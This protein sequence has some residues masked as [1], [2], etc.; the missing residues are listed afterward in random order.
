[1]E[2]KRL[3]ASLVVLEMIQLMFKKREMQDAQG[4]ST[5]CIQ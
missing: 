5:L 1:M 3:H 4:S 2:E